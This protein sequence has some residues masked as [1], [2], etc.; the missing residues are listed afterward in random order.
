MST[1][2]KL[3]L[4]NVVFLNLKR[5]EYGSTKLQLLY[6]DQYQVM[7]FSNNGSIL[8]FFKPDNHEEKNV[9]LTVE[10]FNHGSWSFTYNLDAV[11]IFDDGSEHPMEHIVSFN[12]NTQDGFEYGLQLT[13]NTHRDN[14]NYSF[15]ALNFFKSNWI[16]LPIEPGTE[17]I[18]VDLG[19]T[20]TNALPVRELFNVIS[21]Q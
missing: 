7:R 15:F 1:L 10:H 4:K 6:K 12:F 14:Q 18:I 20:E 19:I 13:K 9:T 2:S 21:R 11:E 16:P 5:G 3:F 17:H 8:A